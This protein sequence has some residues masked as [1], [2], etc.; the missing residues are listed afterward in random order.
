MNLRFFLYGLNSILFLLSISMSFNSLSKAHYNKPQMNVFEVELMGL[1][2]TS[3]NM[4]Y[5]LGGGGTYND[6]LIWSNGSDY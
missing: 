2:C 3:P 5:Y 1:V 4:L 6:E